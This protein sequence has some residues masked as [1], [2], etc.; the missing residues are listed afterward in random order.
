MISFYSYDW[1]QN[2]RMVKLEEGIDSTYGGLKTNSYTIASEDST[3]NITAA[4]DADAIVSLNYK[5]R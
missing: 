1:L 4:L 2:V 5:L 3:L